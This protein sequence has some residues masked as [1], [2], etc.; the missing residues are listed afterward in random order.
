MVEL[1]GDRESPRRN[2]TGRIVRYDMLQPSQMQLFQLPG[3]LRIWNTQDAGGDTRYLY[4]E[5]F[6][7]Q[8]Y[9]KHGITLNDGDVIFDVGA[10]VGMFGLSL[11]QRFR[12]LRMYCFEPVPGTYECLQRNLAEFA[13]PSGH[14]VTALNLGLGARDSQATIE[15]F[16]GVPSNSTLYSA[17]KHR[18]FPKVLDAIRWVDLWAKNKPRALMLLPLFPFRKRLVGPRFKRILAAGVSMPCQVRT[19][20]GIIGERHIERIDLLKI[21]VEGAEM[22]VLA[23]I[24][25]HHW[26]LIKQLTMEVEAANKPHIPSLLDRL[27]SLGFTRIQ[28]ESLFGGVGNL[29]AP[30]AC[31]LFAIRES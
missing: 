17:E 4:G 23:G 29:E 20:S 6:E 30:I 16:P 5:I 14:E 27:R 12:N 18:D 26:P 11:M 25:E 9:E 2:P 31:T 19:L 28:T 13:P 7:R 22:D 24:E 8:C 1:F 10:N 3:G 15:F 21:D